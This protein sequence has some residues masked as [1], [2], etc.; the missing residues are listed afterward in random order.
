MSRSPTPINAFN[1][2]ATK[3]RC[4][5]RT[6]QPHRATP[7]RNLTAQ[8]PR[9]TTA[10]NRIAQSHRTTAPRN[11][12]AQPHRAITTRNCTAQPHR[13]TP[14]QNITAQPRRAT[15]LRH[16]TTQSHR[17][18]PP[19]S[20]TA[21]PHRAAQ[22]GPARKIFPFIH[23]PGSAISPPG[24]HREPSPLP[25]VASVRRSYSAASGPWAGSGSKSGPSPARG[26]MVGVTSSEFL[27]GSMRSGASFRW[28][29]A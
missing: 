20:Q 16:Y 23:G 2:N 21:Q 5:P 3:N 24:G 8:P 17:A 22:L 13:A 15:A 4:P 12:T 18:I 10:R 28:A 19:R 9:A 1:F 27:R 7:P 25:R 11:R 14:P 6:L 29:K 26:R